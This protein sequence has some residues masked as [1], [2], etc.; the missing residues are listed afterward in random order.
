MRAVGWNEAAD[1]I[2]RS[3]EAAKKVYEA[4]KID[5]STLAKRVEQFADV[6]HDLRDVRRVGIELRA[7]RFRNGR[8]TGDA[9]GGPR[10]SA[11]AQHGGANRRKVVADVAHDLTIAL[12]GRLD[13]Q[14]QQQRGGR[15]TRITCAAEDGM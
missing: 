8:E 14:G 10:G 7:D 13:A 3:L 12:R 11:I 4:Q 15:G 5:I 6:A 1:L 2:V 9:V